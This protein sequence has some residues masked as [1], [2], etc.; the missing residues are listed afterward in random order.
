M[1]LLFYNLSI[2]LYR[3]LLWFLSPFHDK[4]RK[5]TQGRK[6]LF[7]QLERTFADQTA[8]LAWFHCASLGEFE[9]GRPV[10]E[11]YR[12]QY[13]QHRILLTFFSPSGYE[14]R[15]NYPGAD[16]ICYLPSDTASHAH[17]FIQLT[18]PR[19]A[20]FVKYEFW[21]HYLHVLHQQGIPAISF[22]SIFRPEQLFFKPYGGFYRNLLGYFQHL[23]VQNESSRQLLNSIGIAAVT[24]AGDTRFDRVKQVCEA[25]KEIPL[26]AAFKN[27]RKVL[28][29][30]SSWPADM[31]IL[32]P[33]LNRLKEP[34]KVIIAPHEIHENELQALQKA[35]KRKSVRYSQAEEITVSEA[36]VLII[37]NIGMLSSL[38]QYG[39]FAYIGG[40]FGKG[41]HNI[42]EA[43]T[44]GMPLFFG[45]NHRR[46]KEAIDL[47]ELGAAF[48]I[49]ET[50]DFEKSFTHLFAEESEREKK[51]E[52]T[53][54]YVAEHTGAT[55]Q[56]MDYV[57]HRPPKGEY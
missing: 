42:L 3:G 12:T 9:Q 49:Q 43:A 25:R 1:S 24:V 26:A 41:L 13:P 10:I 35:L 32:L 50:A 17:R 14:V 11:A 2:L 39:E 20:F 23:F 8:P 55:H 34:L 27:Q 22:S 47:I 46:F 45:P 28:V 57:A 52:I 19:I 33:F 40:A 37:D 30:G 31:A 15:K 36:E 56:I 44:F 48:P 6:H 4:A 29:I 54:R 7:S 16:H 5:W 53:R 38:Y 18:K 21:Y 51:A